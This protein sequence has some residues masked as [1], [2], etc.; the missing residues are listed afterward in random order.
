MATR[1][2]MAIEKF[3]LSDSIN[4]NRIFIL[5]KSE[6][7]KRFDPLYYIPDIVAFEKKVLAK[8]PKKLR[9]FVK[10][11]ASGATP[12][13]DEEEKYYSDENNGVPFLR[14]QNVTPYGIDLTDVKHI[15]KETHENYLKRSQV[16]ENDLLITITGRIA[17]SAVAPEGFEGNINQHSV[18]IKTESKDISEKIA[19]YLNSKI[20]QKLALRRTTG[21]TRPALDY[22]ALLSIP[23][24]M[25]ERILTIT[26]K[27]TEQKRQSE[28]A[29]EKLLASI[30]DYLLGELGITM[31]VENNTEDFAVSQDFELNKH[32]QVVKKGRLFLTRFKE[33]ENRIDPEYYRLYYTVLF[34]EIKNISHYKLKDLTQLIDYGLMPTQDYAKNSS[35]GIPFIRVT[36]IL[37]SG[38][39]DMSDT[40]YIPFD[41]PRIDQKRVKANDILMVQ[42]GSTTGKVA[43]VPHEYENYV[44]NSFSFIIR[45]NDKIRQDFLFYILGSPIVQKQIIR[46]QNIVSVRPNTSK[47]AV[48]SLLIPLPLLDKQ[49][50][51]ASH[52]SAIR[53]K[54]KCL[55]TEAANVLENAKQEIEQMILG[56]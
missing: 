46:S 40:K 52:I 32:N 22:P 13:R 26:Q 35:F 17:S 14:V 21:G 10:G 2:D 42:C 54:A 16:F 30:D 29:A 1:K 7:E 38:E 27:A 23:I 39:I 37:Q 11:I 12:N 4:P 36:N 48:E 33:I 45:S 43:I 25:D 24:L 41:T 56:K 34:R 51:I 50:E 55:Q 44:A 53:E 19:A 15:N 28:A 5:Q 31:P 47:P 49:S 8:Q 9:D 3:K 20:G 18:V 6:L